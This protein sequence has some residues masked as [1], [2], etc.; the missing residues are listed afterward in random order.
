MEMS[1]RLK[2]NESELLSF[3]RSEAEE[4]K[5]DYSSANNSSDFAK[6]LETTIPLMGENLKVV[7]HVT[8]DD[9][10]IVKEPIKETKT[11]EIELTH[12]EISIERRPVNNDSNSNFSSTQPSDQNSSSIIDGPVEFRTEISIQ[13][14]REEPVI[15]KT[16]YVK[17]EIVVKK[18]PVTETKSITEDLTYEKAKYDNTDNVVENT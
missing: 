16:P 6:E 8:E 2:V 9:I 7:K 12:E 17:E 4:I 18:K 14:K 5:N 15:T 10:N 11:V 3:E 1:L 13:L